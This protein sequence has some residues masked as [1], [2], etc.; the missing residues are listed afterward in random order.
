MKLSG[1]TVLTLL[2]LQKKPILHQP[3]MEAKESTTVSTTVS[4]F[5]R[6]DKQQQEFDVVLKMDGKLIVTRV[7]CKG[8]LEESRIVCEKNN[9]SLPWRTFTIEYAD[10]GAVKN[11]LFWL[12]TTIEH[13]VNITS[14]T[15]QIGGPISSSLK[16][17]EHQF[18]GLDL[19]INPENNVKYCAIRYNK[20]ISFKYL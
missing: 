12:N 6:R 19:Y 3:A 16:D 4:T 10:V 7:F 1:L 2:F 20:L 13:P 11:S 8:T 14:L 15:S 17:L 18:A 9:R 5:E